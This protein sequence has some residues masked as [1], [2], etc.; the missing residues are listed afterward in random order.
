LFLVASSASFAQVSFG[1]KLGLGIST[2]KNTKVSSGTSYT[3]T[4]IITPQVGAVLNVQFGD[5]FAFRPEMLFIQRGAKSQTYGYTTKLRTS[6]LELP[7]NAVVGIE[8]GPGRLEFFAGPAIGICLGGKY[9]TEGSPYDKTYTFK[10]KKVP[11]PAV[12]NNYAYINPL[13]ISLNFGVDY[14]FNNGLLI[15]MGYNL[16]LSNM[17]PHYEDPAKE[18]KRN[19]NVT[20]SSAV[21]FGVA[22]LFGGKN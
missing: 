19:D 12:N 14:K 16:G 13:N 1:P 6:Y 3:Y 4:S 17:T 18:S 22:Y 11:Y 2:W 5:Y 10:T 20:K 7:I 21:T 15:Q 8:A 9:S